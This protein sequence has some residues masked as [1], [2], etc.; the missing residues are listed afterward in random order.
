VAFGAVHVHPK[1]KPRPQRHR[2]SGATEEDKLDKSYD[3]RF[4]GFVTMD[5][6]KGRP[7]FIYRPGRKAPD[8]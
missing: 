8:L 6:V 3:S 1:A 4:L 2:T 7:Q 5:E